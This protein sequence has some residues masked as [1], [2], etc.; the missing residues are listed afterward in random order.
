MRQWS[1]TRGSFRLNS[2]SSENQSV[3][4]SKSSSCATRKLLTS[5]VLRSILGRQGTQK[6]KMS[7]HLPLE[8]EV[9][10]WLDWQTISTIKDTSYSQITGTPVL[11]CA[12]FYSQGEST[13]V[14]PWG[15]TEKVS[16]SSC[17]SSKHLPLP[18]ELPNFEFLMELLQWLGKTTKLSTFFPLFT[19]LTKHRQFCGNKGQEALGSIFWQK[20]H[21]TRLL[22]A[23]MQTWWQLIQMTKWQL[24]V[25]VESRWDG[26][27]GALSKG[28]SFLLIMHMSLRGILS[29]T[30]LLVG[31]RETSWHFGRIWFCKWLTPGGHSEPELEESERRPHFDWRM[32]VPTSQ[33]KGKG[34][35]TPVR[36]AGRSIGDTKYLM[37]TVQ[38]D[39]TLAR[40]QRQHLSVVLVMF[41]CASAE[42]MTVFKS[43]ILS[44]STSSELAIFRLC[45]TLQ[46]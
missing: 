32:L 36:F 42:N 38:I 27:W 7:K 35:T 34:V 19:V 23:T 4:A 33:R 21:P 46:I 31:E 40:E 2:E 44:L 5:H 39:S 16:P 8:K 17:N 28:W 45:R 1:L 37:G 13:L 41:I 24:F 14:E 20:S 18:G 10:L 26:T 15:Q 12:F 9:L 6:E 43:G 11:H 30:T 3:G 29:T 22:K 25:K